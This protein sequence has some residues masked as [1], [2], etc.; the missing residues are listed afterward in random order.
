MFAL[1][2]KGPKGRTINDFWLMVW[3]ENVTQIVML[4]N[5]IEGGKVGLVTNS[6]L[7][8]K[9]QYQFIPYCFSNELKMNCFLNEAIKAI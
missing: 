9:V 5:L 2:Y 3:Q 4:T 6:L 1:R 7:S 8:I